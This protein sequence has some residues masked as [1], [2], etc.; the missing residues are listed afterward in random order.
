VRVFPEL[1]AGASLSASGR[2]LHAVLFS[3]IGVW[4]VGSTVPELTRFALQ[5]WV[6]GR[7]GPVTSRLDWVPGLAGMLVQAG[8]GVLLFARAKGLSALWHRIRYAD[9]P[10]PPA[11]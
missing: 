5:L 8:A 4:L 10:H 3:A 9:V 1:A 2:D 11:E 6:N 7:T